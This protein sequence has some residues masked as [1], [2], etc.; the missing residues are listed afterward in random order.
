MGKVED[1]KKEMELAQSLHPESPEYLHGV[2][3]TYYKM[4][5][6]KHEKRLVLSQDNL[7]QSK[8]IFERAIQLFNK[9][10]KIKSRIYLDYGKLL[11]LMSDPKLALNSFSEGL[12]I[13]P[14]HSLLRKRIT[15]GV[16]GTYYLL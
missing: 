12:K 3:Y 7:N 9:F 13:D 1:A 11:L 5:E 16:S 6:G 14:D 4:E 10:D 15:I 8:E 2:A